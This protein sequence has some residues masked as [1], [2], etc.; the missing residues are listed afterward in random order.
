MPALR[1]E[2][3]ADPIDVSRLASIGVGWIF[4]IIPRGFSPAARLLGSP[5]GDVWSIDGGALARFAAEMG[6]SEDRGVWEKDVQP[7]YLASCTPC[8]APGGSAGADLST[9]GAWVARRE[10]IKDR[11]VTAKTMPPTGIDFTEE[12]RTA[13]AGWVGGGAP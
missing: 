7:V 9:Y 10:Q 8:H 11:V 3:E 2:R 13:I 6:D 5:S 4:I 12:E 1:N